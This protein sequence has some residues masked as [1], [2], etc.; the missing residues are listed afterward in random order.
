MEERLGSESCDVCAGKGVTPFIEALEGSGREVTHFCCDRCH[1]TRGQHRVVIG[2]RV[3]IEHTSPDFS[4]AD[5]NRKKDSVKSAVTRIAIKRKQQIEGDIPCWMAPIARKELHYGTSEE[6]E[7]GDQ[8]VAKELLLPGETND[9][10]DDDSEPASQEGEGDVGV[11]E[12]N[13]EDEEADPESDP[14]SEASDDDDDKLKFVDPYSGKLPWPEEFR[15]RSG[16]VAEVRKT[17]IMVRFEKK[18]GK[19]ILVEIDKGKAR[20][21]TGDIEKLKRGKER[22]GGGW[23]TS[24]FPEFKAKSM[25]RD[26][27][28]GGDGMVGR[29]LNQIF[30]ETPWE[31]EV[32]TAI[33]GA[34]VNKRRLRVGEGDDKSKIESHGRTRWCLETYIRMTCNNGSFWFFR[35]FID[36]FLINVDHV[37]KHLSEGHPFSSTLILGPV[38]QRNDE[39]GHAHLSAKNIREGDVKYLLGAL[40]REFG[41]EPWTDLQES[42]L[43]EVDDDIWNK[44][45]LR[46]KGDSEGVGLRYWVP[47]ERGDGAE[48]DDETWFKGGLRKQGL[49]HLSHI[50]VA[51]V[52]A[53]MVYDEGPKRGIGKFRHIARGII[54]LIHNDLEWCE[55][56]RKTMDDWWEG[57]IA[58]RGGEVESSVTRLG[59]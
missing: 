40:S 26:Y 44:I 32:I 10:D 28:G 24:Q 29:D 54:E 1:A 5:E 34:T 4:E 37:D 55:A 35:D 31:N 6:L 3:E 48:E 46:G 14:G 23:G 30:P 15:G 41:F 9:D 49:L 20:F 12:A 52:V 11:I 7:I 59:H 18:E 50:P 58:T 47:Y 38:Q 56:D 16:E 8:V 57:I 22:I 33:S 2:S 51:Y 17:T 45:E 21:T 53:Q 25:A 39:L 43:I 13:E 27:L 19:H 36:K 42:L